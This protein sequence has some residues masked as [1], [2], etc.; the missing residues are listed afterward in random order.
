MK[1]QYWAN[2][3]EDGDRVRRRMAEFLVLEAVPL[4]VITRMA[5]RN[6]DAEA[7][8]RPAIEAASLDVKLVRR[9]GWYF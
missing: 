9:P 1:E 5:V 7:I 4:G 8:V 2:T 6:S 3:P